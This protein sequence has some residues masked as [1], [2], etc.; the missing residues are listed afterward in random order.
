MVFKGVLTNP[1]EGINLDEDGAIFAG[2]SVRWRRPNY[3]VLKI[4]CDGA[5]DFG[6]L[7]Q[8]VGGIGGLFFN[9]AEM[10]EAAV[11]CVALM[12]CIEMGCDEVEIESDSYVIIS[13]LNG[14]YVVDA[15]LECFIHDI[16]HLAS[17]L[18][19]EKCFPLE[20]SWFRIFI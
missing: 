5:W 12:V 7:L 3:G 11:I 9:N 15:T 6:G 14:E 1:M 18:G 16:G 2:Q 13:M 4:N 20:C 8:A 19:G 17:Q 10:A